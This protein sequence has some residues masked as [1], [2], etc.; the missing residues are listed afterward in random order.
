MQAVLHFVPA[1]AYQICCILFKQGWLVG[2][3]NG[4]FPGVVLAIFSQR[5][6]ATLGSFSKS[7]AVIMLATLASKFFLEGDKGWP[8]LATAGGARTLGEYC[9]LLATAY[10]EQLQRMRVGHDWAPSL[11]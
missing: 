11:A 2:L 4:V 7:L 5:D 3:A 6:E 8:H 1:A 9:T 10:A